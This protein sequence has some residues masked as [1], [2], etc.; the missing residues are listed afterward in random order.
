MT[1]SILWAPE[2]LTKWVSLR[3]PERQ[4]D[5]AEL[6]LPQS[7]EDGNKA[8]MLLELGKHVGS[9]TVWGS[10]TTEWLV[11]DAESGKVVIS[12]DQEF[13]ETEELFALLD[14]A[15]SEILRL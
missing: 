14:V 6:R 9:F 4:A 15:L 2:M 8:V 12:N 13:S 7:P 5:S 10:G 1:K 3:A 11:M